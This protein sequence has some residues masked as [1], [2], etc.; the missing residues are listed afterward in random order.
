MSTLLDRLPMPR[1]ADMR[2]EGEQLALP[3][4]WEVAPGI[5]AVPPIPRHLRLVGSDAP[6]D[7]TGS[8]PKALPG[9]PPVPPPMW[10]ARMARAIAE[11]ASGDRPAQ[12]LSRWVEKREL[13]VL[14]ARGKAAQLHPS[15]IH[16]RNAR[17]A[18]R[19]LQQVR[20][21]RVCPVAPGVAE[22]SA[23]L[24]GEGRGKAVAMRFE[25]ANNAWQVTA[26]ALG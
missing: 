25:S 14:A 19:S 18:A 13:A 5:T 26:I 24:V 7:V 9:G 17:A 15:A 20:A 23:V 3:L 2:Y 22:T 21:I 11:V 12:Q 10:V 1:V 6:S 8:D 16:G 4:V